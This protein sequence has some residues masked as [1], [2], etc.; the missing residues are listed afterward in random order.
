MSG[1]K[2]LPYKN[3][4]TVNINPCVINLFIL[5]P[6]LTNVSIS[7]YGFLF[8]HIYFDCSTCSG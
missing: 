7:E 3:I 1:S 6:Y 4:F 2:Y 8:L 5:D